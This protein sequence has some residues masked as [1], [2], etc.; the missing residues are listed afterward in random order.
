MEEEEVGHSLQLWSFQATF[1]LLNSCSQ[2][3]VPELSK[4][5]ALFLNSS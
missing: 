5:I 4:T 1:D 2:H 3:Y